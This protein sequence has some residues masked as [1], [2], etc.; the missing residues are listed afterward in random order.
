MARKS[1]E[2]K[3]AIS[4][5]LPL[6]VLSA[7]LA[8]ESELSVVMRSLG[9]ALQL[10]AESSVD[11]CSICSRQARNKAFQTLNAELWPGRIVKTRTDCL[12]MRA[13]TT[14]ENELAPACYPAGAQVKSKE[15]QGR[16]YLP[17]VTLR[18]HTSGQHLVGIAEKDSTVD[19]IMAEYSSAPA[20]TLFSGVLEII[21]FKYGDGPT[22]NYYPTSNELQVH[23]RLLELKPASEGRD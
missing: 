11:P 6:V 2:M 18:F 3:I 22:F 21:E 20:G 9:G 12:F 17:Q 19:E 15:A 14:R 1:R 4:V 13:K 23:C 8:D 16:A 7:V 5:L 10:L